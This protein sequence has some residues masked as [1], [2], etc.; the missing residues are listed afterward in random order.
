MSLT[1]TMNNLSVAKKLTG[2]FAFLVLLAVIIA[3]IS[4]QT[5]SQYNQRSLIVAAASSAESSLLDARTD[6]KNFQLRGDAKYIEQA[7]ALADS[8]AATVAPLRGVLSSSPNPAATAL[9]SPISSSLTRTACAPR[10]GSAPAP[11]ADPA[12]PTAERLRRFSTK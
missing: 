11:K 12:S 7:K 10:P 4:I 8:A 9:A 3:V 5:L 2:G 1:S 6:E